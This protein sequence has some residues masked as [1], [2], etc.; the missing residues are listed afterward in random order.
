MI[1]DPPAASRVDVLG[2]PVARLTFEQ[3]LLDLDDALLRSSK[4]G[5]RPS[6]YTYVNAYCATLAE[7][8]A[9]YRAA[10]GRADVVYADGI[11]VVWAARLLGG[12]CPERINVGPIELGRI[13]DL[14]AERGASVF[15]LGGAPGIA[16]EVARRLVAQRPGLR[17]AGV[18]HGYFGP[19]EEAAV[20]RTINDS[21][22]ALLIVGLGPPKQELWVDRHLAA[23]QVHAAWCMGGLL[24]QVA[25]AVTYPPEW[26]RRHHVQWLYRLVVEPRRLWRRYLL[27]IPEFIG[28][29]ALQRLSLER[30]A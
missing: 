21:G 6:Y 5:G 3:L 2:V 14:C 9:P 11:G 12:P 18:H 8:E 13:V 7:R 1:A 19:E 4:A 25:G 17:I 23:L 28:R 30:Q 16:D 27:G 20:V 22:A 26:V 29:V 15:L 24:D 10:V